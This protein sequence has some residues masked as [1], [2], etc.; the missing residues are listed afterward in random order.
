MLKEGLQLCKDVLFPVFC[1]GCDTEGQ[2]VCDVCVQTIQ[3]NG[4]FGCPLCHQTTEDGVVCRWCRPAASVHQVIAVDAYDTN[5]VLGQLIHACKYAYATDCMSAI[6]ES[7]RLFLEEYHTLFDHVDIVVPV[8]LHRRRFAER[9]FNQAALIADMLSQQLD[10]PL[11]HVVKRVRYT[12]PQAKQTRLLRWQQMANAF[13][14]VDPKTI[15]GKQVLL[16]DD[17]YTTGA[18]MHYC[19]EALLRDGAKNVSGFVLARG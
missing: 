4:F 13:R 14:C 17:V 9:G 7:V 3:V 12:L 16:V 5:G 6:E 1:V 8:P 19:A 2:W 11:A 10:L 18:T 15:G